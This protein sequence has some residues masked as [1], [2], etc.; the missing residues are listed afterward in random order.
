MKEKICKYTF[1]DNDRCDKPCFGKQDF[2]VDHYNEVILKEDEPSS[3]PD[4]SLSSIPPIVTT[5][6]QIRDVL[7]VM[8]PQ[9]VWGNMDPKVMTALTSAC[10]AQARIVE[11]LD[12]EKKLKD[13]EALA[14]TDIRYSYILDE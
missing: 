1:D 13:L 11:L 9:L 6:E 10:L 7:G 3:T 4:I 14:D 12:I 2:C 8:I 5:I